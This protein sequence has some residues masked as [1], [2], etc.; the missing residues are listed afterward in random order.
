MVGEE[1]EKE[2]KGK[3]MQWKEWEGKETQEKEWEGDEMLLG[4]YYLTELCLQVDG[5]CRVCNIIT[6]GNIRLH[7]YTYMY[8]HVPWQSLPKGHLQDTTP[9]FAIG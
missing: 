8:I 1:Q 9:C 2:R 5:R 4:Q 7:M 6:K 3:E